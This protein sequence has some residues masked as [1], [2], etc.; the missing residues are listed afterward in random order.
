MRLAASAPR[1]LGMAKSHAPPRHAGDTATMPRQCS[2]SSSGLALM[3]CGVRTVSRPSITQVGDQ[4]VCQYPLSLLRRGL[5]ALLRAAWVWVPR[6][7][8]DRQKRMLRLSPLPWSPLCVPSYPPR[9]G[10]GSR[11][12][13]SM[14]TS[15]L[16]C[17]DMHCTR[18]TRCLHALAPCATWVRAS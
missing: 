9:R 4:T 14:P 2:S 13:A 18:C 7:R 1:N 3:R 6:L 16:P 17:S 15:H 11:V 10:D 8:R 12:A 5:Q